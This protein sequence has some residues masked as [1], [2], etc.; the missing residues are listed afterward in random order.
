[1]EELSGRVLGHDRCAEHSELVHEVDSGKFSEADL[2]S[3]AEVGYGLMDAFDFFSGLLANERSEQR[4][5]WVKFG[6]SGGIW[7]F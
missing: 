6:C 2:V 3:I 4:A 7:D 5:K 1:M